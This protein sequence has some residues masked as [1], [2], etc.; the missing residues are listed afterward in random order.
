LSSS[1]GDDLDLLP[2]TPKPLQF[3]INAHFFKTELLKVGKKI[4]SL[5]CVK[6]QNSMTS[7]STPQ[8][9]PAVGGIPYYNASMK[10]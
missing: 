4:A 2:K 9:Q 8:P 6:P 10:D 1:Y 3:K 5:I 7:L